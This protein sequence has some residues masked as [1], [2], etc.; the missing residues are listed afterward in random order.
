MSYWDYEYYKPAKPKKVKDG[1][2]LESTKIGATWWSKKWISLLESFGWSNRL[3]RGRS[4][5]RRGQVVDVTIKSGII[6]AKV[7]G[8]SSTPYEV[9][10]SIPPFTTAQW[11]KIFKELDTQAMYTAKLLASEMPSD[12]E[13][14]FTRA[15]VS[16]FPKSKRDMKTKC[17]CPDSAN[18]CKHIAAVYYVIGEE[19]DRDP[20]LIFHLRGRSKD[21]I[22]EALSHQR[23]EKSL[24]AGKKES[25][26]KKKN[27][28]SAKRKRTIQEDTLK[29][30]VSPCDKEV[31]VDG[32]WEVDERFNT[33]SVSFQPPY[34]PI[35]LL[36]RLGPPVFWRNCSLDF[37]TEMQR[38]YTKI[39]QR[40]LNAAYDSESSKEKK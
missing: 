24:K 33:F 23:Q 8:T 9:V 21:Q 15:Q 26:K 4:Y 16:L 22:L 6:T 2:R 12:I 34:V 10:I 27:D 31:S 38:L 39:Q 28:P 11:K 36:R 13:E 18:P 40:A 5:A 25:P 3:S 17:S 35:A 29:K 1:I 37:Y 30:D 20:F 32:F 14:V 7:Q 19:F